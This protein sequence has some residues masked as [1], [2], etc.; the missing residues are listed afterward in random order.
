MEWQWLHTLAC[1]VPKGLLAFILATV[2]GC[3]RLF[4]DA[5]LSDAR[6]LLWLLVMTA[7]GA[8]LVYFPL[9]HFC[10]A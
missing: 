4:S 6:L 8:A 7:A 1:P 10:A 9:A 3:I 5:P 2:A